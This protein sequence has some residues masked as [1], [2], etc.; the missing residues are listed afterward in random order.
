MVTPSRAT[1]GSELLPE[2]GGGGGGGR[3]SARGR[4]G[5]GEVEEGRE[6]GGDAGGEGVGWGGERAGV[7]LEYAAIRRWST[8]TRLTVRILFPGSDKS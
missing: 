6:M 3:T 7:L 4:E 2:R 5:G 1:P 8:F